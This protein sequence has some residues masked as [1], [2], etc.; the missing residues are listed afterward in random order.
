MIRKEIIQ[1]VS[2]RTKGDKHLLVTLGGSVQSET[3]AKIV[4]AVQGCLDH[5]LEIKVLGGFAEKTMQAQAAQVEW[6]PATLEM[7]PLYNWAD[8]VICAGGGTCWELC[9]CGLVGVVGALESHQQPIVDA[10][11]RHDVFA[12]VDSYSE[13][14]EK[15]IS[16]ALAALI[17]D[18]SKLAARRSRAMSLV[19]GKGAQRIFE[20]I[21]SLAASAPR[22]GGVR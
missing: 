3:A 2:S 10:L 14:S 5:S 12:A 16:D 19:D 4:R 13:A 7:S 21:R 20:T 22:R 6:C 1:G 18:P 8:F 11:M 15:K 17:R 9:F